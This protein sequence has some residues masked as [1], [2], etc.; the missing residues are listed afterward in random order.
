[1]KANYL[2]TI[3]L[4]ADDE[5]LKGLCFCDGIA[6]FYERLKEKVAEKE[7]ISKDDIL[8]MSIISRFDFAIPS[9]ETFQVKYTLRTKCEVKE[10]KSWYKKFKEAFCLFEFYIINSID[11]NN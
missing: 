2:V 11:L 10:W 7:N 4:A 3:S 1:M 8:D 9:V 5:F 6:A